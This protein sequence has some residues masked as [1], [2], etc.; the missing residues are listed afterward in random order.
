MADGVGRAR[1]LGVVL[2]GAAAFAALTFG[3]VRVLEPFAAA[4][5]SAPAAVEPAAAAIVTAAAAPEA[6]PAPAAEASIPEPAAPVPFRPDFTGPRVAILLTDVGADAAASRAALT[7]LPAEVGAAMSPYADASK[8]LAAAARAGG[9]EVWVGVPMQP[10]S[11]PKVSP[12]ENTLLVGEAG[13]ENVRRLDWALARI[14]P[15]A[16]I[17]GMM[18]SAFTENGAALTPVMAALKQRGLAFVDAR[19]S[20]KTVGL[21]TA[22]AAGVKAALNAR[23]LDEGGSIAANLA[24]LEQAAKLNGTAVGIAR[25]L[26][27]TV[28]AINAWAAGLEAR[29]VL[30]APV[31]T[32]VE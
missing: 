3:F 8:A 20:P 27:G 25:P 11:W 1:R 32:V 18:G 24:E 16:G 15:A 19:V 30:L 5:A 22:R 21:E 6:A 10:K 12:G 29:G 7:A 2:A 9:R 4:E 31:G 13:A 28:T 23:F 17:T 14:G 26:P